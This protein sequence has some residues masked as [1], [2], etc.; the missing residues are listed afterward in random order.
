VMMARQ[1]WWLF[2]TVA[3][4][5]L[6]GWSLLWFFTMFADADGLIL[7]LFG[8][9]LCAISFAITG[10]AVMQAAE[11]VAPPR[12]SH[13]LNIV[14]LAGGVLTILLVGT[15]VTL[16]LFDWSLVGL[17]SGAALVLAWFQPDVYRR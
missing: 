17:L 7:I 6:F 8:T 2:C 10:R 14:A 15:K 12:A 16:G 1:G 11:N 4:A 9:A 13:A 3:Q 5:A